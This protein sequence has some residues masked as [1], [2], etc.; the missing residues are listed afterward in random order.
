MASLPSPAGID[1]RP[2]VDWASAPLPDAW[3]DR[4]RFQRLT[5]PLRIALNV[6]R[7]RAGRVVLPEGLP[8]AHAL[9]KY[10]LQE[11][12]NL[13][14]G[15][16][17]KTITRGYSRAFD[18]LMLGA[19]HAARTEIAERLRGARRALDIGSG[20]GHLAGAMLRA[21]IPQVFA[22]EPSPYLL[23]RAAQLHPSVVCVQGVVEASGLPSGHFDAAGAC[24]VFHEIP[25]RHADAALLELHRILV[26]GAK[27]VLVEPSLVQWAGSRR[28]LW[29]SH[30]WRGVYFHALA[31]R[32]HEPFA[33]AW[34]R[35]DVAKWLADGGFELELDR[36]SMPWRMLAARRV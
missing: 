7:G 9:P 4:M 27:L 16:Y 21:G 22:L 25:P 23:Q 19:M 30:G 26:P 17:S 35:R 29:R 24:F 36:D 1:S 31:R 10:L 18:L 20:A 5:H 11:F 28:E 14:N 6:Q 3:P 8:G 33:K 15:N 12:H 34:H 13:P 32:V 2:A